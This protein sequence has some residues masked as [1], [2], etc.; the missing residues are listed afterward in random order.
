MAKKRAAAKRKRTERREAERAGVKLAEARLELASLEAGG[1]AARP[2]EVI[3]ASVVEPHAAALECAACG[4]STRV[5][6]HSAA[7]IAD[8][9]GT[10]RPLRVA[11]VRCTRCAVVRDIYFRIATKLAN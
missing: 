11:R 2:I 7:T 8:G 1:S 6:E 4:G 10:P 5:E 3:S 9:A